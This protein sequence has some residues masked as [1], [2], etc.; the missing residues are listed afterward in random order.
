MEKLCWRIVLLFLEGFN[1]LVFFYGSES[2][3]C[4]SMDFFDGSFWK[5]V[6]EVYNNE[7]LGEVEYKVKVKGYEKF[8][9][10]ERLFGILEYGWRV[11]VI[12]D[13]CYVE[14]GRSERWKKV[15]DEELLCSL[16]FEDIFVWDFIILFGE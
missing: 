4:R 7:L 14:E 13:I 11:V 15:V 8:Y 12:K 2:R 6:C 9:R 10:E 3:I 5:I 1:F 16:F